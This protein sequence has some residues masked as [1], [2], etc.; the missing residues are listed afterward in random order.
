MCELHAMKMQN[1]KKIYIS[2]I[3]CTMLSLVY[4]YIRMY[5]PKYIN[6]AIFIIASAMLLMARFPFRFRVN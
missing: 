2:I 1:E 4:A 3:Y 6:Q 5:V